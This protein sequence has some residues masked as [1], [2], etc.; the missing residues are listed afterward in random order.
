MN[1]TTLPQQ[2]AHCG[3]PLK[4]EG[5]KH[6]ILGTLGPDCYAKFG[7]LEAHLEQHGL[8]ELS[9]GTLRLEMTPDGSGWRY[10]EA[11]Q[12]LKVRASRAKLWLEVSLP[13]FDLNTPPYCLVTLRASKTYATRNLL[14]KALE[15]YGRPAFEAKAHRAMEAAYAD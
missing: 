10:P 5:H 8:S 15:P 2:C 12:T 3:K 9:G 6:P 11:I 14:A 4:G 7:G 13:R 1:M